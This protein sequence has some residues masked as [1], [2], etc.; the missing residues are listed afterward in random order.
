MLWRR[1]QPDGLSRDYINNNWQKVLIRRF[2]SLSFIPVENVMSEFEQIIFDY[3]EANLVDSRWESFFGYFRKQFVRC[4]DLSSPCYHPTFWSAYEGVLG[5]VSRTTNVL[6]SW[7]RDLNSSFER[8]HPNI[9]LFIEA[10][11]QEEQK[12]H[13]RLTQILSGRYIEIT[14]CNDNK[15]RSS[16]WSVRILRNS[17]DRVVIS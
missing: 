14:G 11:R 7:H 1:V 8:A 12:M 10:L 15:E 5:S 16:K 17:K 6:E 13:L 2:F 4:P 3:L 9:A